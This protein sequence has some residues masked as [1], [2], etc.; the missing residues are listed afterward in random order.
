MSI[1]SLRP[2]M[3][4]SAALLMWK[5]WHICAYTHQRPRRKQD[6]IRRIQKKAIRRIQDMEIDILEIS[7]VGFYSIRNPRYAVVHD[8][9]SP[10]FDIFSDQE[11][12]SEEE[13]ED[14][15]SFELKGH[16]LKEL[17]DNTFSGSDHE[18]VNE[19]IKNVLDI[20][21]LFH[22]PNITIDQVMLRAFRMSLTRAA[23]HWL[24]NKPSSSIT[25]WEDLKTKF[26]RKY[27]PPARTTKKMEEI[28]NF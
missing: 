15:Y 13:I 26:L 17:R 8:K 6:P 9:K 20:V 23:S 3:C 14:K 22:I 5:I 4:A 12:Y 1:P 27:C 19:H 7:Y 24:R 21:D 16:F 28:N 25:T 10:D 11:E 18:D 2:C